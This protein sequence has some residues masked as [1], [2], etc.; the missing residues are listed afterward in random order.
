MDPN[1]STN[2]VVDSSKAVNENADV[3]PN[4]SLYDHV[5]TNAYTHT[6]TNDANQMDWEGSLHALRGGPNQQDSISTMDAFDTQSAQTNKSAV[7]VNSGGM[8]R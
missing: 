8:F 5:D 1:T 4:H 6:S 3:H 2:A 7:T